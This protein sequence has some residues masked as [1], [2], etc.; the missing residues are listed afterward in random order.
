MAFVVAVVAT[1]FVPG[2][3]R[4]SHHSRM[5][6]YS[7]GGSF[8]GGLWCLEL[9]NKSWISP[10]EPFLPPDLGGDRIC[11]FGDCC[12]MV[13]RFFGGDLWAAHCLAAAA[14]LGDIV[15]EPELGEGAALLGDT[16]EGVFFGDPVC[17]LARGGDPAIDLLG[18]LIAIVL[19]GDS[20]PFRTV[21]VID[22]LFKAAFFTLFSGDAASDAFPPV[23]GKRLEDAAL[24]ERYLNPTRCLCVRIGACASVLLFCEKNKSLASLFRSP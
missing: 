23:V 4:D 1:S 18:D 20:M 5:R 3:L 9:C 6:L 21:F 22:H 8:F 15:L 11:L 13:C 2:G 24:N 16:F 17:V 14:R 7:C 10:K 19:E 12:L